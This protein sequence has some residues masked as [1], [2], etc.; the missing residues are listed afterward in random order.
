MTKHELAGIM[1]FKKQYENFLSTFFL[2]KNESLTS[3]EQ[4]KWSSDAG[5]DT[6]SKQQTNMQKSHLFF[7]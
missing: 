4:K 6:T 5:N 7:I 2:T 3:L 1:L